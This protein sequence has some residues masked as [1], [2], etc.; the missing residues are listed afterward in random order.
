[1]GPGLPVPGAVLHYDGTDWT[2]TTTGGSDLE[3][4]WGISESEIYAVS[5]TFDDPPPCFDP[6]CPGRQVFSSI[7]SSDG[8]TWSEKYV[9]ANK[10][11][12]S[13]WG[14]S[15]D[16]LFAVGSFTEFWEEGNVGGLRY[17]RTILRYDGTAWSAMIEE[18]TPGVLNDVWG[19]SENDVFAVGSGG[20][21]LH[22]DGSLWSEMTSG[23]SEDLNAVSGC[24]AN[25]VFAVGANG[26]VLRFDG[27][28][29]LPMTSVTTKTINDVWGSSMNNVFAVGEN[30]TILHFDGSEWGGMPSPTANSLYAVWGS[31][32][33]DVFAVGVYGTICHYGSH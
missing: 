17:Y 28:A 9:I 27:Q 10:W 16:A 30:G 29:W 19:D 12:K 20:A 32:P 13:I 4:V 7:F 3:A 2:S 6:P 23:T 33:N 14:V 18:T 11:I 22:Y 1:V 24:S 15:G 26:T 8:A 31:A 21:I 5:F 25:D